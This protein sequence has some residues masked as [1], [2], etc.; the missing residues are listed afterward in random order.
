[1]LHQRGLNED[2]WTDVAPAARVVLVL[3]E[4]TTLE[5]SLPSVAG[6]VRAGGRGVSCLRVDSTSKLAA[7]GG[8]PGH[9]GIRGVSV[10]TAAWWTC[11]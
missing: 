4:W 9:Y 3:S 2:R 10:G 1:V 11:R 7:F 5:S 8:Q 6:R